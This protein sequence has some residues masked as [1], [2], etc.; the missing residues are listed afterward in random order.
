MNIHEGKGKDE[1]LIKSNFLVFNIKLFGDK[2]CHC[3]ES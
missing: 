3:K 2:Q 1:T